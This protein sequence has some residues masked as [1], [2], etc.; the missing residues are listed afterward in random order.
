MLGPELLDHPERVRALP[1]HG[2]LS[3]SP[4]PVLSVVAEA[5]PAGREQVLAYLAAQ[6]ELQEALIAQ[7]LARKDAANRADTALLRKLLQ[8]GQSFA[9]LLSARG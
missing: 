2:A 3:I 9:K 5:S 7:A 1:E 4:V 6:R 8:H